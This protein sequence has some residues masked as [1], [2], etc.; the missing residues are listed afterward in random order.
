MITVQAR[1]VCDGGGG[2]IISHVISH[3]MATLPGV[4]NV[5]GSVRL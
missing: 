3:V 2:L 1:N 5:R 4:R